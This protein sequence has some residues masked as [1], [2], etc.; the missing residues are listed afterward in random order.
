[1][2][3]ISVVLGGAALLTGFVAP[4]TAQ[5]RPTL[6]NVAVHLYLEKAGQLSPDVTAIADFKSWNG[7]P[8]GAGIPDGDTFH[9]ILIAVR[10]S[11]AKEIFAKGPQATV[12]VTDAR[13]AKPLLRR[14]LAD[15]YIE[16]GGTVAKPVFLPDQ[17]CRDLTIR[18]AARAKTIV[19]RLRFECGE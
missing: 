3:R 11:S 16:A 14:I 5:D 2:R 8:M 10:F 19:K 12:T 17:G 7:S 13:T 6:E 15:I 1:M 9:A 4:A 18:V